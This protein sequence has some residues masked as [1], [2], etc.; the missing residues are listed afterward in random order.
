M[1]I[2]EEKLKKEKKLTASEIRKKLH[3]LENELHSFI[4]V[5]KLTS[6]YRIK[7]TYMLMWLRLIPIKKNVLTG[8]RMPDIGTIAEFEKLGKQTLQE[9]K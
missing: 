1:T 8:W 2:K 9:K 5:N 3:K 4:G 7:V 6:Q